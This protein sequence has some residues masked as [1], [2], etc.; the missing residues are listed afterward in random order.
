M[1]WNVKMGSNFLNPI[2]TYSKM[3]II[4]EKT[5]NEA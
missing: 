4:K 1:I 5:K 2:I 3:L